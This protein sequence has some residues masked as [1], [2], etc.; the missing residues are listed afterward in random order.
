MDRHTQK[1]R[2]IKKVMK[3]FH[4]WEKIKKDL[5]KKGIKIN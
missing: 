3:I 2:D 5:C 4:R 1:Q